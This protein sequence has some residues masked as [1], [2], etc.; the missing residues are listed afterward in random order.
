MLI[1]SK[2]G[3][4]GMDVTLTGLALLASEIRPVQDGMTIECVTHE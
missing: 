2:R 4:G 3:G 1:P